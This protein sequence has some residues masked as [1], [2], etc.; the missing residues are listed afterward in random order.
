MTRRPSSGRSAR[1]C[2]SADAVIRGRCSPTAGCSSPA[3]SSAA[4]ATDRSSLTPP[5]STIRRPA[6]FSS[7]LPSG[8]RG[9][10][11]ATLLADGRVLLS[12]GFGAAGAPDFE[13]LAASEIFDP[14]SEKFS[15]VG[16]LAIPRVGHSAL[17]LPDGHVLAVGGTRRGAPARAGVSATELFDVRTG[18][19]TAGPLFGPGLGRGDRDAA[20][21]RGRSFCSEARTLKGFRGRTHFSSS[22]PVSESRAASCFHDQ[23]AR[24]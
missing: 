20:G 13:A 1:T 19:W 7:L 12:G 16:G 17:L 3:D 21:K 5:R 14:M 6:R 9:G 4:P 24:G 23:A 11:G 22:E 18:K 15:S 2:W 10:H 8:R